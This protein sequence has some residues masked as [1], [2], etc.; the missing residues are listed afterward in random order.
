VGAFDIERRQISPTENRRRAGQQS[1]PERPRL[2]RRT[3]S[4]AID[5]S[6]RQEVLLKERARHLWR[7]LHW[8]AWK[9]SDGLT[10]PTTPRRLDTRRDRSLRRAI[11]R[12]DQAEYRASDRG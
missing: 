1:S 7:F 3:R 6:K 9:S 11:L 10:R 8:G 5:V 12:R 4:T 2:L